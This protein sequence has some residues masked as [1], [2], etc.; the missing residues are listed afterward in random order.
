VA[1]GIGIDIGSNYLKIAEIK[2]RGD[3]YFLTDMFSLKIGS[4]EINGREAILDEQLQQILKR[5]LSGSS[6]RK[7][8][9]GISGK[10]VL[11]RY[12]HFPTVPS[13]KIEMMIDFEVNQGAAGEEEISYDYHT[14][15]LP[16]GLSMEHTVL[17]SMAKNHH[18]DT[19]IGGLKQA[20]LKAERIQP[21]PLALFNMFITASDR[22]S[23]KTVL[24][25]DIGAYNTELAIIREKHLFFI[26][27]LP[28][29]GRTFTEAVQDEFE[30]KP[31]KA[32]DL[33]FEK[34]EILFE[35]S[36]DTSDDEKL[37]LSGALKR[38]A[39]QL[40]SQIQAS[41]RFAANNIRMQ[42]LNIDEY[43][44]SGGGARINGLIEYWQSML[45]KPVY[46]FNPLKGL[47]LS[48]FPDK[49]IA[50]VT[51][52]PSEYTTAIGLALSTCED[53]MINM[54]ILPET[55]KKRINI[56]HRKVPLYVSLCLFLI[57]SI[58]FTLFNIGVSNE[59][60]KIED[61]VQAANLHINIKEKAFQ[62]AVKS[63]E[64]IIKKHKFIT[65]TAME[66]QFFLKV[67]DCFEEVRPGQVWMES[68]ST[69]REQESGRPAVV[70]SVQSRESETEKAHDVFTRFKQNMEQREE[71]GVVRV[72]NIEDHSDMEKKV[73]KVT[74]TIQP[75]KKFGGNSH[76]APK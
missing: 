37:R 5:R 51:R 41:I 63:T 58:I 3:E 6:L 48:S 10:D 7:G 32:E 35:G 28:V 4:V 20:G 31:E 74:C 70:M 11:Y 12:I 53:G 18:L 16:K 56:L 57:A 33:K 42:D 66:S 47:N 21:S 75:S 64:N 50:E 23:D 9:I 43:Y 39:L 36:E 24:L 72:D 19:I 49:R 25:A 17:A 8:V 52:L 68:I 26:R 34:G 60:S 45:N 76:V 38:A 73:I 62:D 59:I 67:L 22:I 29:G 46:I 13:W 14:L 1:H 69:K 40:S 71:I 15:M 30:I 65:Q 61:D 2:K 55:E 27:T 54:N 44:I